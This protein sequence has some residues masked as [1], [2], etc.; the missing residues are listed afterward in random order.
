MSLFD[1]ACLRLA[2]LGKEFQIKRYASSWCSEKCVSELWIGH[3][4]YGCQESE[5]W[6]LARD[7]ITWALCGCKSHQEVD[8]WIDR[9]LL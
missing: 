1:Y 6:L 3:Y 7:P 5:G 9:M 8:Q 4:C 2:I